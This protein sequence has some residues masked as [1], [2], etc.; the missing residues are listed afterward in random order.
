VNL[1]LAYLRV[2]DW[3]KASGSS[4]RALELNSSDSIALNNLATAYYWDGKYEL[5]V[6]RFEEAAKLDP[7]SAKRQMNLGDALDAVGR[8]REAR[9]AYAK[10][11]GLARIQLG[12]KFDAINAGIAAKSEAKLGRKAEAER[13]AAQ[14]WEA[15]D[16]DAEV[17]YK[18]AAVYALTDQPA[19]ALDK[20]ELAVKLGKPLWE[21][22]ADPDLKS[23]R[24]DARFKSLTAKPVRRGGP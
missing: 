13:W 21:V 2:G 5:A 17:A 23:L 3:E 7:A 4:S 24:N 20:L 19:K 10:A 9:A 11:V 18:V 6:Q 12:K 1:G 16:K 15:N 14:A 8:F 22:R